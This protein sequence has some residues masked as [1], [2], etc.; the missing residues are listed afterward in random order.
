MYFEKLKE[1][2]QN[3]CIDSNYFIDKNFDKYKDVQYRIE[4]VI[5]LSVNGIQDEENKSIKKASM[6]NMVSYLF[7]HQ[8][9]IANKF[10]L[11]YRLSEYYN[12]K[13]IIE[14]FPVF[15][16]IVDQNYY[17]KLIE[18]N[19][20]NVELKKAKKSKITHDK[21]QNS[22]QSILEPLMENYY[23]L[24]D[25]QF[26]KP[27]KFKQ[28]LEMANT[29]PEM[30]DEQ[31]FNNDGI[32]K[33]YEVIKKELDDLEASE[34]ECLYKIAELERSSDS[35]DELYQ[36]LK[37]LHDKT[38][39]SLPAE[40]A[41]YICPLCNQVDIT[42]S[43][44]DHKIL[45]AQLWLNDEIKYTS[46]YQSTFAEDVRKYK[47]ELKSIRK[48]IKSKN[49]QKKSFEKIYIS[50]QE[51]KT[52]KEKVEYAKTHVK[53]YVEQYSGGVFDD[54]D[55]EIEKIENRIR[56][57]SKE[58]SHYDVKAKLEKAEK[59]IN[60]NMNRL[61]INLDFEEEYRP[62]NL[63]FGLIDQSFDVYH[64]SKTDKIYL[65]QMGSGAN[66]VSTHISLFLSILRYF[67]EQSDSRMLTTM[68]FDQ[69]SQVYFPNMNETHKSE[70]IIAVENMYQTIFDEINS[71][72]KDTNVL[73]QIIIVDHVRGDELENKVEF[74]SYIKYK[75]SDGEHL[76]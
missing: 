68:F 42:I 11:F 47:D 15:A 38:K 33:Q 4:E 55:L 48:L 32:W 62:I 54:V 41:Q 6:R 19:E 65:S 61:A 9:L 37:E 53:F 71:I 29:L 26:E 1:N 34:Q 66:W 51:L 45:E 44:S 18:L 27:Q 76:I 72:K 70:D 50:S 5:G 52:K 56:I 74:D 23:S 7:Q 30:S 14:Q 2:S 69:P 63:N 75:W 58:I 43:E 67:C 8:N 35:G 20:L 17:T 13:P 10:A 36:K 49:N 46:S 73:P 21:I 24:L 12:R 57:L 39:E 40:N 3:I 28:L 31:L 59:S 22:I 25:V 64:K 60:S 16:G